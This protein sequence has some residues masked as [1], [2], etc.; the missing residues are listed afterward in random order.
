MAI[1]LNFKKIP[2]GRYI[3]QDENIPEP[4]ATQ[5]VMLAIFEKIK[6]I[7]KE[8]AQAL[9]KLTSFTASLTTGNDKKSV[10]IQ[11]VGKVENEK[12]VIN[13]SLSSQTTSSLPPS[14]LKELALPVS[15]LG[16][17]KVAPK[18]SFTSP[19][20]F[21][22]FLTIPLAM[23]GPSWAL[24]TQGK[25][26]Q[27]VEG[28]LFPGINN[29]GTNCFMN[30]TFQMI[31]NDEVLC[32][33]LVETFQEQIVIIAAEREQLDTELK[34]LQNSSSFY[35]F[36]AP[37]SRWK[38]KDAASR[39]NPKR[40]PECL[41]TYRA[42]LCAVE[43]YKK[44]EKGID[45]TQ[46]RY[47]LTI[48]NGSQPQGMGD[49]E[50]FFNALFYS[51]DLNKYAIGFVEGFERTYEPLD[52][53]SDLANIYTR[54][55]WESEKKADLVELR[56]D[57]KRLNFDP[58]PKN[59]TTLAL[60]LYKNSTG[61]ELLDDLFIAQDLKSDT[62]TA[63]T[64]GYYL[65][66]SEKRILKEAPQRFMVHLKRFTYDERRSNPQKINYPVEMSERLILQGQTYHLKS[67]VYHIG[68]AHYI[69]YINKQNIWYRADDSRVTVAED[70]K[71]GLNKGYLY[72]YE[73]DPTL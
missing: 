27:Q 52:Q 61:Q 43:A 54:E 67:I 15:P 19:A 60:E 72:F 29:P 24:R 17:P 31:M 16:E 68:A 30:A 5:M 38:Q 53:N 7:N 21:N 34:Q 9:P 37:Y 6:K 56:E 50:E 48:F 59:T 36:Q 51:V 71:E 40:S 4:R 55:R 45:L 73:K 39:S 49:A 2:A 42:F 63:C 44:G 62:A 14:L 32:K 3:L 8:A 1:T 64:D 28:P 41:E 11:I 69:A 13:F 25:T 47:L 66:K 57:K 20:L 35:F 22:P 65:I 58:T 70:L 10:K 26:S 18:A 23:V 33:A 46:L 12:I